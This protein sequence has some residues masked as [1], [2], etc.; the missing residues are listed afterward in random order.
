MIDPTYCSIY[1]LFFLLFKTG[2]NDPT[3]LSF[4][5]YYI[6]V[7]EIKDFNILIDNK[8]FFDQPVKSKHEPFLK[9]SLYN[10][11]LIRLFVPW[12][13]S[14]KYHNL[15]G[16][17]LSRQTNTGILQEINFVGKLEEDGAAMF[18]SLKCNKKLF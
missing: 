10:R 4:D 6:L 9:W 18:L 16:I 17:D 11:N 12:K 1:R 3:W 7:V 2:N 5:E 13:I 8:S 14:S 15:I